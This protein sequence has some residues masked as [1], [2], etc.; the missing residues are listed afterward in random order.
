MQLPK[1]RGEIR[2]FVSQMRRFSLR[3]DCVGI[4]QEEA[5]KGNFL[6]REA[7][8]DLLYGRL[9]DTYPDLVPDDLDIEAA[10]LAQQKRSDRC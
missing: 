1:T 2:A 6:S 8:A 5:E 10:L 3:P 4:A 9:V 7:L